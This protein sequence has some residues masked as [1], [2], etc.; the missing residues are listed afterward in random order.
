[1]WIRRHAQ[2]CVEIRSGEGVFFVDPGAFGVP[3]LLEE[4]TAVMVTHSHFDHVDIDALRS[5]A[6][7]GV[8]IFGPLQLAK[9]APFPIRKVKEGD[10]FAL[11]GVAIEIIGQWQD[12]TS[13]YDDPIQNVG[14]L[15]EKRF[16]HPGDALP[17][18]RGLPMVALPMAAPWAKNADLERYVAEY[19]PAGIFAL[20][21]ITLNERG[22]DFALKN[23]GA[24]A[25]RAGIPFVGLRVGEA[26]E[27]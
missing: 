22:V 11:D 9:D 24:I 1:M 23:L 8:P 17:R 5:M 4:A 13:I 20:H 27:L 10:A 6:S 26:V 21:D 18:R 15:F 19:K 25:E 3:E 14:Y 2:A 16:L 7:R 12:V